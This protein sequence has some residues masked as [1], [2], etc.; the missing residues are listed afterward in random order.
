M[1]S[2]LVICDVPEDRIFVYPDGF[3]CSLATGVGEGDRLTIGDPNWGTEVAR[4]STAVVAAGP[5]NWGG[6]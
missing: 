3:D 6:K 4:K 1:A 5:K 2:T